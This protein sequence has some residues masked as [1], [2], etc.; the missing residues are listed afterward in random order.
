MPARSMDS[1]AA[2]ADRC[3][4]QASPQSHAAAT[5]RRKSR[6]SPTRPLRQTRA[7]S[8]E[9]ER[10]PSV[11]SLAGEPLRESLDEQAVGLCRDHQLARGLLD[12]EFRRVLLKLLPRLNGGGS[13]L[14]LGRGKNLFRLFL[15]RGLQALL[16]LCRL[17][18][19]LRSHP[20]DLAVQPREPL[21]DTRKPDAGFLGRG[22]RIDQVLLDGSIAITDRLWESFRQKP[23]K[24]NGQQSEVEYLKG[25]C[26][27]VWVHAKH[28]AELLYHG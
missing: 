7:H 26:G 11:L 10:S 18:L 2:R 12:R 14:L 15:Q 16:F 13:D 21:L 5:E 22:T 20:G 28:A 3:C 1:R 4:R 19:S 6:A 27:L 24:R 9:R 17:L 25:G 23:A 8:G